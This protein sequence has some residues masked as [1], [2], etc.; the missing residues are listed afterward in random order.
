MEESR[1]PSEDMLKPVNPLY[2]KMYLSTP[3]KFHS[4]FIDSPNS[5]PHALKD[6][7]FFIGRNGRQGILGRRMNSVRPGGKKAQYVSKFGNSQGVQFVG[8]DIYGSGM[9]EG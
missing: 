1:P 2:R 8:Y 9:K 4:E 6:R 7:K 5:E 3:T